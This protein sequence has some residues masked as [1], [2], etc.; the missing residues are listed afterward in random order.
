M[1][2]QLRETFLKLPTQRLLASDNPALF[3]QGRNL[4]PYPLPSRAEEAL[5]VRQWRA[6]ELESEYLKLV[7][8]PELGGRVAELYD[9][10]AGRDVFLP[11]KQVRPDTGR[12]GAYEAGGLAFHFPT[13]LS[14]AAL[15]P[16]NCL[17]RR[18]S[19]GSASVVFG[20]TER[21]GFMNWSVELRLYPDLACLEQTVEL[22]NPTDEY[23]TFS[24]CNTAAVPYAKGM[25][26]ACPFDWR[27]VPGGGTEKWPMDGCL[28]SSDPSA[29]PD[30]Y[31]TAGRPASGNC[32]GAYYP[33]W[34]FG[35]AHCAPRM[36][37]KGAGFR[38]KSGESVELRCGPFESKGRLLPHGK[39]SWKEYWFGVRGIGQFRQASRDVAIAVERNAGSAVVRLSPNGRFDGAMVRFTHDGQTQEYPVPLLPESPSAMEFPGVGTAEKL[40]VDVLCQGR[41]LASLGHGVAPAE[42][43]PE[44]MDSGY[45]DD[46]PAEWLEE[47]VETCESEDNSEALMKLGRLYLKQRKPGEAADCFE[48][49]LGADS[50]NNAARFLLASAVNG[51]G[52]AERARRLF[53]DIPMGDPLFEAASLETAALNIRLDNAFDNIALLEGSD[54]PW[55]RFLTAV[56]C[57]IIG[58]AR[59]QEEDSGELEEFFLA[60]R[61]IGEGLSELTSFTANREGQLVC[62]ALEYARLGL[63]DDCL[64]V[65][66]LVD[67]PGMKTA[68]IKAYCGVIPVSEALSLPPG[69]VFVNEP[70]LLEMLE[71]CQ[72]DTGTAQWLLG[73]F[74]HAAGMREDA[75]ECW[76]T[77]Y[78]QSLRHSALLYCLGRAYHAQGDLDESYRYLR[79]D[80]SL[81]RN[82]NA[83]SLSL[84]CQVL[85]ERGDIF[86]RLELLPLLQEAADQGAVVAEVARALLDGGLLEETITL[87]ETAR[88]PTGGGAEAAGIW[89]GTVGALAL[90]HAGEGRF[91][92]ARAAATRMFNYPEGL[93]CTGQPQNG[94]AEYYHMLGLAYRLTG[95]LDKS[96]EAFKQGA[97]EGGIQTVRGNDDAM[98][99]VRLC[100]DEMR[101]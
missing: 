2:V 82:E 74:K 46:L 27:Q 4:F 89:S 50:R 93:A 23:K 78:E 61:T 31:E 8:L 3:T 90:K 49:A 19:D 42:E 15:E 10:L 64:K 60:E 56:S 47:C 6:F 101:Y 57:R 67:V 48:Q 53:M 22:L 13:D 37:M 9:K 84:L 66:S 91:D 88:F 81:H 26:M 43:P 72:D 39:L 59:D 40:T 68:L 54:N 5:T 92:E 21:L 86:E 36:R 20:G 24:W 71:G 70:L 63:T 95:D 69:G 100:Q 30:G 98:R 79:E 76:L 14:P 83:E 35:S 73:C 28:D 94:R 34:D 52:D 80:S 77:A 41:L 55:G 12:P 16:V 7:V 32:F 62:I 87:L 97:M 25:R 45:E 33:E 51:C 99:W 75:L 58:L 85:R 18:Y 1:D 11:L 44:Y 96:Y 65:L 38:V 29:L 17:T